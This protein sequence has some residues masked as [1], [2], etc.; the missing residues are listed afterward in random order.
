MKRID[1]NAY[2]RA[3]TLNDVNIKVSQD[4]KGGTAV[5]RQTRKRRRKGKGFPKIV[6]IFTF[7]LIIAI[8][9]LVSALFQTKPDN[10]KIPA[11]EYFTFSEAF[12]LADPASSDN[13]SIFILEV[14]FNMTAVKGEA[15][16]LSVIPTQGMVD[17]QDAPY[18]K[19]VTANST[20]AVGPIEY[21]SKVLITREEKGYP[22]RFQIQCNEAQGTVT[23]YVTGFV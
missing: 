18:F 14:M 8:I 7:V 22:L 16:D 19:R 4:C 11:N 21:T 10:Q 17:Q 23:V 13:S 9:V 3:P 2:S 1:R 15:T 5:A 20:F 6:G 12:A